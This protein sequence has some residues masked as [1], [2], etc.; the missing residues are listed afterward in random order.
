MHPL[1]TSTDW[2]LRSRKM[3]PDRAR[4]RKKRVY[5]ER[6]RDMVISFCLP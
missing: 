5:L 4:R 1:L 2:I 3:R 6:F